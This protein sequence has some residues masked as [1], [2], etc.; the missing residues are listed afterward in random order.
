MSSS[1]TNIRGL[2]YG[3]WEFSLS[4]SLEGCFAIQM[5]DRRKTAERKWKDS[6]DRELNMTV[7]LNVNT[8]L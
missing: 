8:W 2:V 4:A 7:D 5:S 6:E 3:L 1:E